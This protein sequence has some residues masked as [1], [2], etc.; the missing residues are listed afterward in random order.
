MGY[1]IGDDIKPQ[2]NEIVDR[3]EYR[4][5]SR[6]IYSCDNED[7]S[8]CEA[9]A[10]LYLSKDE[11][12]NVKT[13]NNLIVD[14]YTKACDGGE[15]SSCVF[16]AQ[17]YESDNKEKNAD[18]ITQ[19]YDKACSDDDSYSCEV[20]ADR[21]VTGKNKNIAKAIE[22]YDN[23]CND[24]DNNSCYKLE[25]LTIKPTVNKNTLMYKKVA[26]DTPEN[27]EL[28]NQCNNNDFGAC[29]N[30]GYSYQMAKGKKDVNK[31]I[32]LF[33]KSCNGGFGIG[34]SHLGG[35]YEDGILVKKDLKRAK[36][37]YSYGCELRSE[38]ACRY[39]D[40]LKKKY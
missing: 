36:I 37:A 35:I 4:K 3:V 18:I 14:L 25:E 23:L 6:L 20:L 10:N 39:L 8:S 32:G 15:T 26:T 30:L 38:S 7:L 29:S 9:L 17:K 34:C 5:E 21:Y 22:I 16:L 31:I 27:I 11:R 1:S 33:Y 2:V 40:K 28:L 12:N 24:G 13:N 19:L